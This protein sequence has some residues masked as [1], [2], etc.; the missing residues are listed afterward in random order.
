M[1]FEQID[2]WIEDSFEDMKSDL[3]TLIS[4]QSISEPPGK[5]DEQIHACLDAAIA[6]AER[7]GLRATNANYKYGFADFAGSER[8]ETQVS[9]Y[10]DRKSPTKNLVGI[11]GHLDVVP[12][13]REYWNSDPFKLTADGEKLV[14]RGSIDDKGPMI[15]ALYAAYA[16]KQAGFEPRKTLRI[17]FGVNEETCMSDAKKYCEEQLVPEC[18]FTPD[19]DWPIIIGEKGIIHFSLSAKWDEEEVGDRPYLLSIESGMAVNSVPSI[20]TAK[21]MMP[22]GA[23]RE[24][25]ATGKAAHGSLPEL[26]ENAMIKL[27][28]ELSMMDFAPSGAKKFV[29]EIAKIFDDDKFGTGVGID[30]RDEKSYTTASPNMCRIDGRG[31]FV[32]TDVRYIVSDTQEKYRKIIG[33]FAAAHGWESEITYCQNPLNVSESEPFV[34][35]MLAAYR[36]VT[37]DTEAKPLIIGGGT[38]AK[39][40]PNFVAFGPDKADSMRAHQAN[41]YITKGEL[42]EA[43][44]IYARAIYELVR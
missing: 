38:Y 37:G 44:K 6:I 7:M 11:L 39:T 18:G 29:E 27:F 23:V 36:E 35:S 32:A 31:G 26:G 17:I 28:K 22:G 15:A 4:F 34:Q 43:S 24:I 25:S 9:F 21:I 40:I 42:L 20:A 5:Y 3:E 16:L 12:V 10:E 14:A 8:L 41:E 1:N 2:K 33:E 19:A 13:A 30:G